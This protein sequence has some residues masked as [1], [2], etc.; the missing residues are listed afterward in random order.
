MSN[1]ELWDLDTSGGIMEQIQQL[2]APPISSEGQRRSRR[3]REREVYRRPG[4]AVNHDCCD[5]CKEGGDL[6]CC[7]R[8]PAAFHL[9]CH[10]PPLSEEGLPTGEWLC[11]K[12]KTTPQERSTVVIQVKDD[13][14]ESTSSRSSSKSYR[15][16]RQVH[17]T[18]TETESEHPLKTLAKAA[19]YMNPMQF[20]VGK[21]ISCNVPLPGS[22]KRMYGKAVR[23]QPKK[24]AHELD[25]GLVPLPAKT[26]FSCNKSCRVAPLIQCDYCPLLFHLDCLNPP[27]TSLPQGRWMCPNHVEHFLDSNLLK[28]Q[29]LTERLRLWDRYTNLV[30]SHTVKLDFLNKIHRKHPMFRFKRKLPPRPTIAVPP[31]IK[32]FYQNPTV[33]L[34]DPPRPGPPTTNPITDL[35]GNR[36]TYVASLD[37]QEEWLSG[38]VSMQASIAKYLA[39]KQIQKSS[40]GLRFSDLAHAIG[41]PTASVAP[42]MQKEP[43]SSLA[44]LT[45]PSEDGQKCSPSLSS[46]SSSSSSSTN[47]AIESPDCDTNTKQQIST[48]GPHINGDQRP[49][50]NNSSNTTS[51]DTKMNSGSRT[52]D[53]PVR[54]AVSLLPS[55]L[56]NINNSNC[57]TISGGSN[58]SA[59]NGDIDMDMD[60]Q[61]AGSNNTQ[62]YLPSVVRGRSNS[63]DSI[64]SPHTPGGGGMS[65]WV[66]GENVNLNGGSKSI[67][68]TF[69]KNP[70]TS[71][72]LVGK[73]QT[74]T[75]ILPNNKNLL[76]S[77]ASNHVQ[78]GSLINPS[79]RAQPISAQLTPSTISKGSNLPAGGATNHAN[80]TNAMNNIIGSSP[81]I[82]NLNSM[83]QQWI[84]G[85][86]VDGEF[87][88]IDEQLTQIL[89]WQRLQQ[90]M[91]SS[92]SIAPH[93]SNVSSVSAAVLNSS[94]LASGKKGLLNVYL[95]QQSSSEVRSRAVLCPLSGKGQAIPMPYRSLSLGT[96]SS[97]V[98]SRAVLCPLSGKGQAIP[99]PYRSL[100]LGTGAD[101]DVKLSDYGFCNFISG[102]HATIFYDEM[103]RHF[104]LLNYSEHGTTVDNVLYSC[105]FSDKPATTP[106]PST[107]VAAVR[108]IINRGSGTSGKS[109]SNSK[110]KVKP[111]VSE[112]DGDVEESRNMF[113]NKPRMSARAHEAS[114][115]CNCKV[116][117][118][119][120]IGGSGAGWEGT[121]LLHHGSY[122]KVGC[123]Q[124]VF[125][126]VDHAPEKPRKD[127]FS[128]SASSAHTIT[129]TLAPQSNHHHQHHHH[130]HF[131]N[132]KQHPQQQQNS[133][134]LSI[135][136]GP[137]TSASKFSNMPLL[138]TSQYLHN[139]PQ[140][141][142]HQ[143]MSLLKTHLKSSGP[144]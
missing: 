48:A 86:A 112:D 107:L 41:K 46:S 53:T 93:S 43:E 31:A 102:H 10:D 70:V 89:A 114:K 135:Y 133:S 108:G 4:R 22:S 6:L 9:L 91:P 35:P 3:R 38:V 50:C 72:T 92:K 131:N 85:N 27:L 98:R 20:D 34:P 132:I 116:S 99:M 69:N 130:L 44:G 113:D 124:F 144:P 118:S 49:L 16:K 82:A 40:D 115:P 88:K 60:S 47:T 141:Q 77:T 105:D 24:Q 126:I 139:Q 26:C 110:T 90:L 104:E 12:C 2:V 125:S 122:V 129:E 64:P 32:D 137:S 33:L 68:N 15:G 36:G 134:S 80:K 138:S 67:L 63:V 8:C 39:Q 21:E 66:D 83:L 74:A 62:G 117:S 106:Q 143:P 136:T 29:S 58:F 121:A 65:I 57:A 7:D 25:N 119:S 17:T 19:R 1:A 5:S 81:T 101:M 71:K 30:D 100:S 45:L 61:S 59:L 18:G 28:S 127:N 123:L 14:S 120:L 96:G 11:H 76:T 97:E 111:E 51:S 128:I 13:D 73:P 55:N 140:P 78:R 42:V 95:S 37:E 142:Q 52:L 79:S 84:E 75:V 109:G 56:N 103:S 54:G 94:S 87:S 23:N